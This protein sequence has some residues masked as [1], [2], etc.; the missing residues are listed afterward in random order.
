MKT[1]L[2]IAFANAALMLPL[3]VHAQT[4]SPPVPDA[5]VDL[6]QSSAVAI[7][8]G[9]WRFHDVE[10]IDA[11]HRDPGPDRM[12][13]GPVNRTRDIT[14]KA[15]R[16]GSTGPG[17]QLLDPE[18]LDVRRTAGLLSMGWY[19]FEF[20][21]PRTVGSLDVAGASVYFEIVVDDYAEIWVNHTLP[22]VLGQTG[23]PMV[24]G[25]NAPNRVLLTSSA[26]PGEKIELAVLAANGP[27]SDPPKNYVWI[28]SATLDFYKP[29]RATP[30]AAVPLEVERIDPAID[31]IVP[32]DARLERLATGFAFTEGPVWHPDGY[33]LFSDPNQNVIHR[34]DPATGEV[35]IYRT[36]SGYAG[37]DIGRYHQPGSNGLAIDPHGRLTICEHGNRRVSRLERNGQVTVLAD[38]FDGK[39]LNSPNDLVYRSDGALFF[40]DPP[41][42]LPKVYDDPARESPYT[43]VY[44]LKDDALRLV[45]NDLKGP[46]GIAFAP[47]EKFLYVSNWDDARKIIMRYAV[48]D[49][50]TLSTGEVFFDMTRAPGAEA[51]DGLKV[52]QQGNIYSS[53]PGGVWIIS[54]AGVHLGTLKCPELP[55]NMAWGGPD[56][57]TLYLTARTGLYRVGLSIPGS[58]IR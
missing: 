26:T 35:S 33:L 43:G 45:S 20:T 34:F 49:D 36:K 18:S 1:A 28:R 37:A 6:S 24:R 29:G 58:G 48:G 54:P 40:T 52:D 21:I 25:W 57:K 9:Q 7:V 15:G 39:R 30:G 27:L 56:G 14:P 19:C 8:R 2:T 50:A 17:W 13:S 51:L 53:G 23:G 44:S 10:I 46:N 47:D 38:A 4:Q 12:P 31:Q 3:W 55:A 5:I 16:E 41:F 22:Q 32:R 42:G 11:A